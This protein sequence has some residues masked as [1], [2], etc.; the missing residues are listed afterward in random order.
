MGSDR[1]HGFMMRYDSFVMSDLF[2]MHS[3]CYSFVMGHSI[4]IEGLH[5]NGLSYMGNSM[6]RLH[7]GLLVLVYK[8]MNCSHRMHQ[9]GICMNIV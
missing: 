1:V 3:S 9:G 2:V 6:Y 8:L 7:H 5:H 4:D